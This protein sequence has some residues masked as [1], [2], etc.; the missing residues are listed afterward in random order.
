MI[1]LALVALGE[2]I[3][4]HKLTRNHGFAGVAWTRKSKLLVIKIILIIIIIRI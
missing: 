4:A 3:L 1:H 2:V